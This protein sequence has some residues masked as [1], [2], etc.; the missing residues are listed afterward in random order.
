MRLLYLNDLAGECGLVGIACEHTVLDG[1][2]GAT[3]DLEGV[4]VGEV[5]YDDIRNL[6]VVGAGEDKVSGESA[7][8]D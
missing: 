2:V 6:H 1:H 3:R 8:R 7:S 4:G 5:L